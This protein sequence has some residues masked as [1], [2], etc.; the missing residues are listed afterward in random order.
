MQKINVN[1]KKV[2]KSEKGITLIAL[3]TTVI[4]I[5]LI[6]VPIALHVADVGEIKKFT[7]FKDDLINLKETVAQVYDAG[8]AFS[9]DSKKDDYI[10]P[11]FPSSRLGFLSNKQGDYNVKNPND[12]DKYYVIDALTLNNKLANFKNYGLSLDELNYGEG[13]YQSTYD[14]NNGTDDVYIINNKS[15]TIYYVAGYSY[16][17][18][19]YYRY[20]ESYTEIK[21]EVIPT[22]KVGDNV[23]YISSGTYNW[24]KYYSGEST[25]G[26]YQ[27]EVNTTILS[28]SGG[29]SFYINEWK[30]FRVDEKSGIVELIST[31]PTGDTVTLGNMKNAI[32]GANGYN[33]GVKL[34][35]NACSALY[36]NIAKG[37]TARSINV[38]DIE[39]SMFEDKLKEVEA[40][41]VN[42]NN[43]QYGKQIV[44]SNGNSNLSETGAYTVN[45][46]Y[47]SIYD[48]EYKSV[49]DDVEL[50]SGI[51]RSNQSDFINSTFIK[52]SIHPYQ[53]NWNVTDITVNNFKY[54]NGNTGDSYY[55]LLI[56]NSVK[57]FDSY[58]VASRTTDLKSSECSFDIMNI[59][60][61]SITSTELYTS[62]GKCQDGIYKMR[63]IVTL[64]IDQLENIQGNNWRVK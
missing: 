56:G 34:L 57:K 58:W 27:D 6:S 19:T 42:A 29:N 24:N 53:T 48:K 37:I 59:S 9:E 39:N 21:S 15:R 2:K 32:G 40:N 60:N 50:K 45:K 25:I 10:G 3:V 33:N 1:F 8:V 13:N 41:Y 61:G 23:E 43:I 20:Q 16:K 12:D 38:E 28:S 11:R 44:A 14:V 62:S 7:K 54:Q 26:T 36:G 5:A 49:V 31:E 22:L 51:K 35:N 64:T 63:P 55:D 46:S 17:G 30:V 52:T 4:L 18:E 47:P